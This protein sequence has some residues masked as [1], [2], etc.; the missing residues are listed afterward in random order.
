MQA[1]ESGGSVD[2][3]A[4][5]GSV[6]AGGRWA[7]E[8]LLK[9]MKEGKPFTSA[10]LRT[11]DTL[12]KNEWSAIDEVL[13]SAAVV[14]LRGIADL[15]TMGLVRTIPNGLGKTVFQYEKVSDMD[16]ANV[17]MDGAVQS[18]D[19]RVDFDLDGVPLPLIHKDFTLNLR[20]L[21]ASRD[22]GESL[23]TTQANI[24]GRII[25]EKQEYI[26]FNGYANKFGGLS[27]YGYDTAQN[28]NTINYAGSD[29]AQAAVWTDAATTGEDI[30]ADVLAMI[31]ALESDRMFGPYMLYIGSAYGLIF[32]RDFK[33]NSDKSIR[34]RLMEIAQLKGITVADQCPAGKAFLV[35]MTPDVV[36]LIE[37]E[38]LQTVQWDTDGG[39]KI[40]FKCFTIGIPLIKSDYEGHCGVVRIKIA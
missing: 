34:T 24:A 13:T 19:G 22:R 8:Q 28:L 15:R 36:E 35:Q 39:F 30:L 3:G 29:L 23:D 31:S 5:M 32:E 25:A 10:S 4:S 18:E 11:L 6:R 2:Y 37:G 33:S 7:T 12:R 21:M 14:R 27:I 9:A 20:T 38:P 17:S 16:P 26:L 40:R 1:Q